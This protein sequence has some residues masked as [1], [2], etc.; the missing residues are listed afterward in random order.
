MMDP[1]P[2]PA[3]PPGKI[4]WRLVGRGVLLLAIAYLLLRPVIQNYREM[5][6]PET[7]PPSRSSGA[8]SNPP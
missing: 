5:H 7:P 4:N 3:V 8:A 6:A 2:V 1:Q